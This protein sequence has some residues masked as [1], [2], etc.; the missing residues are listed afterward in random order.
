MLLLAHVGIPVGVIWLSEKTIA[1]ARLK[2]TNKTAVA[3]DGRTAE[4]AHPDPPSIRSF[5]FRLDYRFLILGSMLP[6][7][8]DKPLGLWLL[9]DIFSNGRIIAHSLLFTLLLVVAGVLLYS[10]QGKCGVL[11]ISF[12]VVAHLCLDQIWLNRTT[13][14]WPLHGW[15]FE[16]TDINHW[17]ER[18]L[19]H[20]TTDPSIWVTEIIGGLILAA[21]LLNLV[22][23]KRLCQFLKNG[24]GG[25]K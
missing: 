16:K 8:I 6:D 3:S 17:L 20:L 24:A 2:R 1:M 22:R 15:T 12:G 21:F 14:L 10:W 5:P 23:Q 9:A 19:A 7:I 18:M 11:C 4:V 25:V 13:F